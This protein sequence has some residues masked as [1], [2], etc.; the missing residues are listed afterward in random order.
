MKQ[1]GHKLVPTEDSGA[2]GD[3]LTYY[4]TA[5]GLMNAIK[6]AQTKHASDIKIPRFE[7]YKVVCI[8]KFSEFIKIY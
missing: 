6:P 2:A 4:V 1:S 7:L 3:S 8:I 5:L